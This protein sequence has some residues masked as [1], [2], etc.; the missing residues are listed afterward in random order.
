MLSLSLSLFLEEGGAVFLMKIIILRER[1][2]FAHISAVR[3]SECF[4]FRG[5]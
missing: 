4:P 3:P 5:E 2:S 1:E